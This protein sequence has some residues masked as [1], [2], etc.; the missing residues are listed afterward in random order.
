MANVLIVDAKPTSRLLLM[1]L[2]EDV[3]F[4]VNSVA[5]A[6]AAVDRLRRTDQAVVVVVVAR[7]EQLDG[8][9]RRELTAVATAPHREVLWLVTSRH[10]DAELEELGAV[11]VPLDV[12][13]LLVAISRAS[14]QVD[15]AAATAAGAATAA[16]A[17]QPR[18]EPPELHAAG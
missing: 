4:T 12:R 5:D 7:A 13:A 18:W 3:G 1:G 15:A 6:A 8:L 2:L 14:E 16:T 11:T 10:H 9:A 17:A